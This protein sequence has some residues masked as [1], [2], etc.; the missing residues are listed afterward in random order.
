MIRYW[1]PSMEMSHMRYLSSIALDIINEIRR[2][3]YNISNNLISNNMIHK[4][5][6]KNKFN[7]NREFILYIESLNN[8]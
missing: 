7:N 1:Y 5:Y 6:F 4:E 2:F 3:K 8:L